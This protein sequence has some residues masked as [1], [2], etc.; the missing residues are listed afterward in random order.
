ME[1]QRADIVIESANDA[2]SLTVLLRGVGTSETK[3]SAVRCKEV[4]N[5]GIVKLFS[6]IS[7]Q[8]ESRTT[9]LCGDIGI[10]GGECGE[11]AGFTTERKCPH[12]MR[13]IIQYH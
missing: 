2:L 4:S 9:K 10:K 6:V 3:D 8:S 7:L 11:G 5:G 12:V 13:E 1:E